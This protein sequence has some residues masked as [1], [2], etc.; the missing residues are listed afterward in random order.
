MKHQYVTIKVWI[1]TRK[2]LRLVAALTGETI[3]EVI[4]R[5]VLAELE[6]IKERN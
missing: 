1:E 4:H 2:A 3:V 6:H 5:L